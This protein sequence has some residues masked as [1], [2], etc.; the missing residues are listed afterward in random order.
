MAPEADA[1]NFSEDVNEEHD[2]A[3]GMLVVVVAGRDIPSHWYC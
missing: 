1:A 2:D 3:I